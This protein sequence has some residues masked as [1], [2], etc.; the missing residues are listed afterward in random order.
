MAL[1]CEICAGRRADRHRE[2]RAEQI[3]LQAVERFESGERNREIA[4]ALQ[5][6]DQPVEHWRQQWRERGEAGLL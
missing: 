2:G 6:S 1:I 4:T 5:V 3:R